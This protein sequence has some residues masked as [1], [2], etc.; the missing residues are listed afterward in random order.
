MLVVRPVETKDLN[1]ILELA[2]KS[3]KG[4]TSLPNNQQALS[5]KIESSAASF[6]RDTIDDA[7]YFLLALEDSNHNKVVGTAAI[8]S[9]TGHRQAFYAYRLMSLTH[10]SHS[11][12]KQTRS[13]LLHLTNDYTDY[14]EVS[15]L[16][17]DRDYRGNGHWLARSR[18]L[19]M[20]QFRERFAPFVISELRGSY[21]EEGRSPFWDAIGKHFFEMEFE[22]A[23]ELCGIGT[24]QF[25]TDLM[26]RYPIYTSMLP[27]AARDVIGVPSDAGRQA[28]KLLE[29]EGFVYEKVI[30]IF[31][32]GPILKAHLDQLKS[33]RHIEHGTAQQAS[34]PIVNEPALIATSSL[35]KFRAV[36]ADCMINEDGILQI[37]HDTLNA[38]QAQPGDLLKY[39]PQAPSKQNE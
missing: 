24:N 12:N 14:S 10:Y 8:H 16:Y 19:L 6:N 11:L 2:V 4:T 9:R 15:T 18:Y 21:N 36:Y 26:P 22:E 27:K 31:D 13:E 5:Q 20:G 1:D 23:D 38:L 39:I 33:V 29:Q 25:I 7:D 17:V 32:G 30:D 3:G 28:M 37:N 34:D 35:K